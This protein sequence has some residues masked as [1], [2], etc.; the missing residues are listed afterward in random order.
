MSGATRYEILDRVAVGDFASVYRARDRDLGREVAVKQIHPQFLHDERQLARYWQ[1]AQLLAT[2]Q[3]PNILTIYD[4]VRPRGWLIVELMRGNLD[5]FARGEP[6]DLEFLRMALGG[7]LSALEFLHR[8]G[9]IHGD[10]KPS[11]I[12]IDS[13]GRVKLG[14][15][16]LAR[17]AANDSGSLLKGTT[18]YMAPELVSNQFGP[19]GPASDIYSLGFSAFELMVGANNFES[20]FPGLSTFGRDKQIAWM[21]WHAATDRHLPD[22]N[23]VLE[24]VPDDLGR[25]VQKMIVKDQTRRYASARQALNDLHVDPLAAP[26]LPGMAEDPEK[27][28]AEAAA[29][30]KKKRTR[31]VAIGAAVFS[32]VLCVALLLPDRT[33]PRPEPT[34]DGTLRGVV[35]NVYPD[36]WRIAVR[37]RPEGQDHDVIKEFGLKRHDRVMINDRTHE[38]RE[39]RADD[40]IVIAPLRDETGRLVYELRASRPVT[41]VGR[42]KE[43][44]PDEARFTFTIIEGEEQGKD[45]VIGVPEDLSITLNSGKPASGGKMIALADL[46]L[47]DRIRVA[48]LGEEAGRKAT[49]VAVQR[50]VSI[51]GKISGVDVRKKVIEVALDD[52]ASVVEIPY[53]PDAEVTINNQRVLFDQ[54]LKPADL[55]PGDKASIAYDTAVTRVNAHR[56]LGEAGVVQRVHGDNRLLDVVKD[57]DSRTTTYQLGPQCEI[58]LGGAVVQ[59]TELREGD[60]VDVTHDTPGA[61]MPRAIRI[62]A[63]RPVDRSRWAMLVANQ[64][65]EDVWLTKLE[66]PLGDVALLQQILTERYRVPLD[67]CL[68]FTD[69]SLV[70][71]EQGLPDKLRPIGAEA[72]LLFYYAGHAYRDDEGKIFLAPKNFDF[73]RIATTGLP[74]QWLVNHLEECQATQKLL[75]LDCSH[76]GA[77]KDLEWQPSTA[78][79]I[80]SLKAST[81]QA[82]LRTVTAIVSA[83]AG[84][85]GL[86]MPDGPHSLFAWHLGKAYLGEADKNLDN[87][88]EPT[89][90]F[91]YLNVAMPAASTPL[92][93]AQAPELFLPNDAP[94]RLSDEAKRKIRELAAYLR[95]DRYDQAA[96]DQAT[97]VYLEASQLAGQEVE[98]KELYAMLLLKARRRDEAPRQFEELR[99]DR[100]KSLLP[101]MGIAWGH[102]DRRG[103]KQAL[104]SLVDMVNQFA[105]PAKAGEQFSEEAKLAAGWAG[106][107]REFI[108]NGAEMADSRLP[109]AYAAL[110][111]A[112]KQHGPQ[113]ETVYG[114][115]RSRVRARLAEFDQRI[116]SAASEAD[117]SRLKVE[118]KQVTHYAQFPFDEAVQRVL[119]GLD[120]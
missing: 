5:Q 26:P 14:D 19:V 33:P 64:N 2:L 102:V 100:P 72:S 12:L 30:R 103:Y 66:H 58:T 61:A 76:A 111:A 110:D 90:L 7:C 119:A 99:L 88:L 73:K 40:L 32:L 81:G 34:G 24:G 62:A 78:E 118:R 11:N 45:V 117:N 98:P 9:V 42:V 75:L 116:A 95:R 39:L 108:E 105:K 49:E 71:L 41:H 86:V 23:R 63:I 57:G 85:R 48:H 22:I 1:E 107:L 96:V 20:L 94:P 79:M 51:E 92:G 109:A 104:D 17:R 18:K 84:Q 93:G 25:V 27:M 54:V 80:Q 10:I 46:Q 15:F 16:G 87:R 37:T 29:A 59:L 8:N 36:E 3:H 31:L 77:G 101:L 89:E 115:G 106:Q 21:M 114:Q 50:V 53:R 28:A 13:Q 83:K 4:I 70:R 97:Q 120:Q 68:V 56:T 35:A 47:D 52:G 113:I 65:Y 91:T 44:K 69:E 6:I 38:L 43:V 74:L 60:Q 67:Q 82:A 112:I 55:R